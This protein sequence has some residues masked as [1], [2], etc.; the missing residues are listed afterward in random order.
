MSRRRFWQTAAWRKAERLLLAHLTDAQRAEWKERRSVT[1]RGQLG[2]W[3]IAL[4]KYVPCGNCGEDD[5]EYYREAR[6]GPLRHYVAQPAASY[7]EA[8]LTA[9]VLFIRPHPHCKN[10]IRY[11][12]VG[13]FGLGK[14]LPGPDVFAAYLYYVRCFERPLFRSLFKDAAALETL[15]DPCYRRR[16][17]CECQHCQLARYGDSARYWP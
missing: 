12:D 11:Y 3:R 4:P 14:T 8:K 6:G 5:C 2:H 10:K 9:P 16:G 13:C 7:R 17:Y 15:I 1:H